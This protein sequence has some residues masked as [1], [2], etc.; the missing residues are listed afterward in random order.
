MED[1]RRQVILS[2]MWSIT[3]IAVIAGLAIHTNFLGSWIKAEEGEPVNKTVEAFERLTVEA[4][5]GSLVVER[6]KEYRLEIGKALTPRTTYGVK[7]GEMTIRTK[8]L[9][10]SRM[11]TWKSKDKEIRLTVPDGAAL[12][13]AKL[14]LAMGSVTLNGITV[15]KLEVDEDMGSF[16][17]ADCTIGTADLKLSMGSVTLEDSKADEIEADAN[18]GSITIRKCEANRITADADMGS[19]TLK[20]KGR[21]DRMEMDLNTD[22]GSVT[23]DGDKKGK[24]YRQSGSAGKIKA[25]ASMGS[26]VISE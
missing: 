14:D 2:I 6:G 20:L 12:D 13:A 19:I 10:W 9:K 24:T 8:K 16:T 15:D 23:V 11:I 26:I 3:L 1:G 17:G 7:N 4:D 18:M 5:A 21:L 22:M 25:S